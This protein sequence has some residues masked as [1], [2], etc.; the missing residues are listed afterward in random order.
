MSLRTRHWLPILASL[1]L[2]V[3]MACTAT[4]Q[5]TPTGTTGTPTDPP[6]TGTPT[7]GPTGSP[8]ESPTGSPDESPTG[9]PDESPTSSPDQSPSTGGTL[10]A[11]EWQTPD[12]LHPFYSNTFTTSKAVSPIFNGFITINNEGEWIPD[13]A[14]EVPTVEVLDPEGTGACAVPRPDDAEGPCFTITVSIPAG[15]T[16]SDG[17]DLTVQDFVDTYNWALESAKAGAGCSGCGA[18]VVLLPETDLEAPLEEQYAQ[19]NQYVQGF[20]VSED[21]LTLT[22]NFQ[23]KYAGWLAWIATV[24]LPM[25]YVNETFTIEEGPESFPFGPGAEN[26][27]ASGPFKIA[28]VA[29]DG[30]DYVR[31]DASHTPPM[32]DAFRYR[33]FGSK[34]GMIAAW[35]NGEVDFID[36][37]TQADYPAL[38]GV[39][40]SVGTAELHS[41]WQY[42]HLDLQTA[43]SEVGLDNP[44][45]RNAIHQLIDKEDLWNVLFPGYPYE[46]ACTNA[47]PGTWWRAED[48][49]C[50]GYDPEAADAALAE[51]GWTLNEAGQRV[52]A[53]GTQMRL[54]MCTTS[55]NPTRLTT[56]GKV[57]QYLLAAGIASD[58]QTA[59]AASVYFADWA[60]TTPETQCSIYRGTYDIALFTYI[61]GGDPGA[62]YYSL[63]HSSQIPSDNNPNGGNDTRCNDPE[64]D[65]ALEAFTNEVEQDV[66]LAAARDIQQQYVDLACEIA[67]YYRAEP[68]GVGV[69]VGGFLQNPSTAGPFWNIHEWFHKNP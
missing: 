16:W 54:R 38:Q 62:L 22:V 48:V 39:D 26:W 9:S 56:L 8:D 4:P 5:A 15:L 69:N 49:T 61:L 67:L 32:L 65:A 25:H 51:A 57:N 52:N 1:M 10:I 63:Y 44:A 13:L 30:I 40:P 20:D 31:N 18:F 64:F 6:A 36:N 43:H 27:P 12:T 60:A 58:I 28:A 33:Y 66:L 34:D 23:R 11:G 2:V 42:E 50:P 24:I 45:V 35:L 47:P 29:T 37:M 55:G 41:A 3:V 68:S 46:E 53:D 19:E 21:G 14:T 59:D 17:D 7:T